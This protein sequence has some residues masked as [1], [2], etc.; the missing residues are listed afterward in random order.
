MPSDQRGYVLETVRAAAAA[1]GFRTLLVSLAALS[2]VFC[3]TLT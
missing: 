2:H 1:A 3:V